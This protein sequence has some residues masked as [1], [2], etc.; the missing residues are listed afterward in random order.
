[1]QNTSI[2]QSGGSLWPCEMKFRPT[3]DTLRKRIQY[4]QNLIESINQFLKDDFQIVINRNM[5]ID[6]IR[7]LW[8]FELLNPEIFTLAS[9]NIFDIFGKDFQ[10]KKIGDVFNVDWKWFLWTSW[11]Q[12]T[13]QDTIKDEVIQIR[14]ILFENLKIAKWDLQREGGIITVSDS[15][16]QQITK[17]IS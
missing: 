3:E 4:I 2:W 1:M 11:L 6:Q 9:I 10:G 14:Q 17:T 12:I 15:T 8:F 5:S 7:N 13:L 16:A